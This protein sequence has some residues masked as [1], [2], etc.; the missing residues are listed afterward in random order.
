MSMKDHMVDIE[1][2]LYIPLSVLET[3]KERIRYETYRA[4]L[5]QKAVK[6]EY[7][8]VLYQLM[9]NAKEKIDE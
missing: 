7:M 4:V 1:G 5:E 8:A 3:E 6:P 9:N 2:E